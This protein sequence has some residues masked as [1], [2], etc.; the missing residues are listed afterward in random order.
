MCWKITQIILKRYKC[1]QA[2]SKYNNQKTAKQR[3]PVMENSRHVSYSRTDKL[4]QKMALISPKSL[5]KSMKQYK[6]HIEW[7]GE[8]WISGNLRI[9]GSLCE[10]DQIKW[11]P[12]NSKIDVF[13]SG[14]FTPFENYKTHQKQHNYYTKQKHIRKEWS[15]RIY[16]YKKPPLFWWW[17]KYCLDNILE[18]N[19]STLFS[20]FVNSDPL[21]LYIY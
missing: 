6:G 19:L 1:R 18:Q 13:V 9:Q 14:L 15:M 5:D 16:T 8:Q 10:Y 7:Q 20:S 2:K 4:K 3:K 11:T 12:R 17:I 21:I